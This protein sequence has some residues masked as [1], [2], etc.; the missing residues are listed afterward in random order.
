MAKLE[1]YDADVSAL[2]I[3]TLVRN[4]NVPVIEGNFIFVVKRAGK[5]K[6][7]NTVSTHREIEMKKKDFDLEWENNDTV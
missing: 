4:N 3:A 6:V 5:R 7:S 2:A 1:K